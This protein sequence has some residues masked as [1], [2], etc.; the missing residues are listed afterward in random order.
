MRAVFT[1]S[2]R[3]AALLSSL[4]GSLVAAPKLRLSTSTIGPYSIAVGA[5][6]AVQTL[7]AWNAGDGALSGSHQHAT[8]ENPGHEHEPPE[9]QRTVSNR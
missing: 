3:V 9:G 5:N 4:F 8:R 2:L 6:G 7:E 1:S